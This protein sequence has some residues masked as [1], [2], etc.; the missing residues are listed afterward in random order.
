MTVTAINTTF[1]APDGTLLQDYFIPWGLSDVGS[2]Y[3]QIISGTD[4]VIQDNALT[5]AYKR[6]LSGLEAKDKATGKTPI[7]RK[8]LATVSRVLLPIVKVPTNIV[9]EA[10]QYA[11]G[12]ATGSTRL[13]FAMKRGI[14]TLKP[15]EGD[16]IMR[17]LKKGTLGGAM[18]L[19]GFFGAKSVGGYFQAGEK[20]KKTDLRPG[21][22][23]VF[24][25]A[26]PNYLVHH[27][28][29]E[30]LQLGATVRRV[31]DS[32]LRKKDTEDQGIG[33]GIMAGAMGLTEEVPFVRDM[34][35]VSKAFNPHERG[36]FF[37]ETAK[38]L[39]VPQLLQWA[40]QHTD[41]DEQGRLIN[42]KPRTA[43]ERIETAIPGLRQKVP[44]DLKNPTR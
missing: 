25:Q 3:T 33:A 23:R 7:G 19:L 18:L 1:T 2:Q 27:P 42:R 37:G 41:K 44:K 8:A 21:E 16:L 38:S 26:V 14:E 31:A 34:L 35:E 6:F 24:D 11:T 29:V 40:A 17:E 15:E 22:I 28:V 5:N 13:G 39:A 32:K 10:V 43:T 20:R 30:T 12:L 36:A 9:G 4:G